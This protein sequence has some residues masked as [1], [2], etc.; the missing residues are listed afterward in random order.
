MASAGNVEVG[1][2]LKGAAAFQRAAAGAAEAMRKIGNQAKQAT[3]AID[4]NSDALKKAGKA[5]AG[6][7]AASAAAGFGIAKAAKAAGEFELTLTKVANVSGATAKELEMLTDRARQAGIETQFSPQAAA[8]GLL[9]LAQSG[10]TAAQQVELLGPV[11]GL[12]AG[13]QIEVAEAAA[14]ATRSMAAFG[15]TSA[16]IAGANDKLLKVTQM[17]DINM[18]QIS[19]QFGK[20]AGKM[21]AFGQEFETVALTLG[22][23]TAATGDAAMA[24]ASLSTATASLQK[25][26]AQLKQEFGVDVF[27]QQTGKAR[28]LDAVLLDLADALGSVSEEQKA[29]ALSTYLGQRGIIAYSAVTK[30]AAG[31]NLRGRDAIAALRK[32]MQSATG[33]V[34]SFK[35]A[36]ESTFSGRVTLMLGS[37]QTLIQEV[38]ATFAVVL[39]PAVE[40]VTSV[41]NVMISILAK[42]PKPIKV[43][44]AAIV[45]GTTAATAAIGSLLVM[46]G[47]AAVALGG[48]K[49]ALVGLQ[50]L[51][52]VLVGQIKSLALAFKTASVAALKLVSRMAPFL[53]IGS[54]V[55]V[56]IGRIAYAVRENF[57]A[58]SEFVGTV[59]AYIGH[60]IKSTLTG[61]VKLFH[62]AFSGI[63][64]IVKFIM[65]GVLKL[66]T[67]S[68][69][70]ITQTVA[71]FVD[72][73]GQ[74]LFAIG[75]EE[76]A[77]ELRGT[78]KSLR[79]LDFAR[80]F[81]E[82]TKAAGVAL[83]DAGKY[84]G[85]FIDYGKKIG[86]EFVDAVG[87]TIKDELAKSMEGLKSIPGMLSGEFANLAKSNPLD[88]LIENGAKKTNRLTDELKKA[89]KAAGGIGDGVKDSTKDI[90]KTIQ[91]V[92]RGSVRIRRRDQEGAP[93]AMPRIVSRAPERTGGAMTIKIKR[94]A[95]QAAKDIATG[96]ASAIQSIASG[97]LASAVSG[98]AQA[99]G[100][101]LGPIAGAVLGVVDAL[102]GM[103]EEGKTFKEAFTGIAQSLAKSVAP[104]AKLLTALVKILHPVIDAFFEVFG[105]LL[106][107]FLGLLKPALIA[108]GKVFT[109]LAI[110]VKNIQIA[111]IQFKLGLFTFLD[112]L[113]GISFGAE[114][115]ATRAELRREVSERNRLI[116]SLMGVGEAANEA[117]EQLGT[118][119]VPT[120]FKLARAQ[121]Q[122]DRGRAPRA[123]DFISRPGQPVQRFS[124]NDT[125]MG[126][127]GNGPL[128][129]SQGGGT[130]YNIERVVIQGIDDPADFWNRIESSIRF[131]IKRGGPGIAAVSQYSGV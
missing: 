111:L 113:P 69:N 75:W 49:A 88:K 83:S 90:A 36:L 12:A 23:A 95:E 13:G 110:V 33:T 104:L 54:L 116:D 14:L 106:D 82:G 112:A 24:Q 5:G 51:L 57:H 128:G 102:F 16:D 50:L 1:L 27:D 80:V 73:Y 30:A 115:E 91:I 97:Q 62:G 21:G 56:L 10:K 130:T 44:L 71:G 87:M 117:A 76:E 123:N 31:E 40:A 109:A 85:G 67:G 105:V 98:I 81:E 46:A 59:M 100:A 37:M 119:N 68:L 70:L 55:I 4:K 2:V 34:D 65:S 107:V 45:V 53:L 43:A 93:A 74:L 20:T 17:L 38:G 125:V 15:M 118:L 131:N 79:N 11:L 60:V 41:L 96:V 6:L 84:V 101:S 7:V 8:E 121:F 47:G 126:F 19:N 77:A 120:G 122:A 99:F 52:P 26:Q 86:G 39:K 3:S 48:Y 89:A 66:I 22:L 114:I 64:Q 94:S 35:S 42:T 58:V 28:Q 29:A 63:F 9:T 103:T 32:E 78:I 25:K 108:I 61:A 127:N 72:T 124:P 129:M 18:Q 92:E